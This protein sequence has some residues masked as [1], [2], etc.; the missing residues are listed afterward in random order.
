MP[1][2]TEFKGMPF[3]ISFY[4]IQVIG[5]KMIRENK[6]RLIEAIIEGWRNYQNF[7]VDALKPLN[8]DELRLRAA[9]KL[10]S[11]GEIARH[12]IGARSRWFY[13]L[14]GEGGEAFKKLGR[15]DRRG[16]KARSAV[17]LSVG[18][19]DTWQGM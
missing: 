19:E 14:M 8:E 7:L 10:R 12:I 4:E 3:M 9:P 15:W 1:E 5:G 6:E 17:E 11:V 18:L 16:A 2:P 13:L